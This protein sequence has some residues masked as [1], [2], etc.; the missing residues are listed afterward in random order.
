[1]QKTSLNAKIVHK[2]S[3]SH[4]KKYTLVQATPKSAFMVIAGLHGW[5]VSI[6]LHTFGK[7]L[8]SKQFHE[9]S[10][11][12]LHLNPV[13]YFISLKT[14]TSVFHYNKSFQM[15]QLCSDICDYIDQLL[16]VNEDYNNLDGISCEVC[17]RWC[18][19]KFVSIASLFHLHLHCFRY[20]GVH[21]SQQQARRLSSYSFHR[22]AE[23]SDLYPL[24]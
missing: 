5:H 7:L 15:L 17:C 16:L 24:C 20:S 4:Y 13:V 10:E 2:G 1:M 12:K 21:E 3:V 14:F 18:C 8:W 9:A 11:F 23:I 22:Y 6:Q 19:G